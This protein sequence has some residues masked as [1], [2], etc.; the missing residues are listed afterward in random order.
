MRAEY[1]TGFDPEYIKEKMES[2]KK[3]DS[4]K[5][6]QQ[7]QIQSS[8]KEKKKPIKFFKNV[9]SL[10]ITEMQIKPTLSIHC[11]I[12]RMAKMKNTTDNACSQECME[13]RSPIHFW[14]D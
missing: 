12:T 7:V 3:K 9:Q 13:R 2:E 14:Q 6:G 5:N 1:L 8:Q 11:I 4:I 10:N